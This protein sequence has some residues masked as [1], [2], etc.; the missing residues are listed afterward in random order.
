MGRYSERPQVYSYDKFHRMKE[1][2]AEFG[3]DWKKKVTAGTAHEYLKR[4]IAFAL[5]YDPL[6]EDK[7]ARVN[8]FYLYCSN[9]GDM[10]HNLQE[11]EKSVKLGAS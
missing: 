1:F 11:F 4:M 3:K 9:T 2:Y 6:M 5:E 10:S 7:I 8:V